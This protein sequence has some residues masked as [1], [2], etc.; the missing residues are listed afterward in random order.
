VGR[1]RVRSILWHRACNKKGVRI[2]SS[3]TTA[4]APTTILA[5][6]ADSSPVSFGTALANFAR[7]ANTA[8][9]TGAK[10]RPDANP[11]NKHERSQLGTSSGTLGTA[12]AASSEQPPAP[13]Q[14]AALTP[15]PQDD[16]ARPNVGVST[17][18][19][20]AGQLQFAT[21]VAEL[22]QGSM[23]RPAAAAESDRSATP[24]PDSPKAPTA[25]A[26]VADSTAEIQ[27]PPDITASPGA[28][29]QPAQATTE[30]FKTQIDLPN[31]SLKDR[32]NKTA[33]ASG[34]STQKSAEATGSKAPQQAGGDAAAAGAG[35]TAKAPRDASSHDGQAGGGNAQHSQA[36][37]SQTTPAKATDVTATQAQPSPVHFAAT[38]TAEIGQG[39]GTTQIGMQSN[40]V[41]AEALP[42]LP[43]GDEPSGST[44]INAAKL[45]QTI[46]QSEMS[47]GMHSAE[48]GSVSIRTSISQQQMLTQISV[49][50]GELGQ[51]ISA[52]IP[53]VQAKLDSN[54]GLQ[55]SIQVSHQTSTASGDQGR[56]SSQTQ[57]ASSMRPG[58]GNG[59]AAAAEPDV[60]ISAAMAASA[61]RLDIQA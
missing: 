8:A 56:S 33:T 12:V 10:T 15:A 54:Y 46:G 45:I 13:E 25:G 32:T 43:A 26:S 37:A 24:E 42:S 19:A 20:A 40:P 52:H 6:L 7:Q 11:G 53:T 31:T 41:R 27:L 60:G 1:E 49:D 4:A 44:G 35:N 55:S 38:P 47:V 51:A 2:V 17:T 18:M 39:T 29:T 57:P 16:P 59:P 3:T 14:T 61:G 36:D 21:G 30:S 28:G 34:Q 58:R 23:P 9:P 50:H 48:F 5:G 22:V